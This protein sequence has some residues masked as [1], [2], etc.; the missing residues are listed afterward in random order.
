MMAPCLDKMN[1]KKGLYTDLNEIKS[2]FE[3]RID[4]D[5]ELWFMPNFLSAEEAFEIE[6]LLLNTIEWKQGEIHMFGE[7]PLNPE[8]PLGME[9]KAVF[10]LMQVKRAIQYHGMMR[11]CH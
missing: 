5:G 3:K 6:Q 1:M 8:K 9:M 4:Q 7:N 11:L 10:T 2:A